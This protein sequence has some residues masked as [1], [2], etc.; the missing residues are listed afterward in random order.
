MLI[1]EPLVQHVHVHEPFLFICHFSRLTINH[2]LLILFFI[3][4]CYLIFT[5]EALFISE[6]RHSFTIIFMVSTLIFVAFTITLTFLALKFI[7]SAQMQ[8]FLKPFFIP[9]L[10]LDFLSNHFP[11][12]LFEFFLFQDV[13]KARSSKKQFPSKI[14]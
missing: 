8:R 11:R 4:A 6:V 10:S 3:M 9:N 12:Q 13:G 2:F 7:H 14:A 1:Y 5:S